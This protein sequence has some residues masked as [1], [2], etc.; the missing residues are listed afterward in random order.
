L[1]NIRLRVPESSARPLSLAL[2]PQF[3]E[4]T[5]EGK[6]R[7]ENKSWEEHLKLHQQAR[8]RAEE[9]LTKQ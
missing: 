5:P 7:L 9:L 3:Q 2:E 1:A 6:H 8:Q 4:P